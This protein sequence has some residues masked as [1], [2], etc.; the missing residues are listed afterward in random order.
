MYRTD[1][2]YIKH[3][4]KGKVNWHP[5]S[6]ETLLKASVL[7]RP[8]MVHIG[9]IAD[10][11]LRKEAYMLFEN[12][13][14]TEILNSK[15]I[16]IALDTED[17]PEAYL[18]GMD[19][20]LINEQ[21]ISDYINIFFLPG[22]KPI[23]SFSSMNAE[24]FLFVANNVSTTFET[25]RQK[26]E[27]A[28]HYL[29]QQLESS[30]IVT[31]KRKPSKISSKLLHAYI[32]SWATRFLDKANKFRRTP[33]AISPKNLLFILEYAHKYRVKEYLHYIEETLMHLYHSPMFDPIE[34]GVFS[35][36][37]DYCF[38]SPSYHKSIVQNSNAAILFSTA[39][40]Y[41][42]NNTFKEAAE[43]IAH[44]MESSMHHNGTGYITFITLRNTPKESK[45]YKYS[46]QELENALPESSRKVAKALGMDP[47]EDKKLFQRI[48]NT[49]A[50]W[51][52]TTEELQKLKQIRK[53]RQNEVIYDRRAI[54]GYN[55]HTATAFCTMAKN[56][57]KE[58]KKGYTRLSGEIIENILKHKKKE[59]PNLYKY[60]SSSKLEYSVSDLY[61]YAQFLNCL[62]HHYNLT[63]EEKYRTL[64]YEYAGYIMEN[65]YDNN[66]GMFCKTGKNNSGTTF[67]RAP[68]MDYNTVSSNAVMAENLLMLHKTT[69]DDTTYI[70]TFEQQLYN[71]EHQLV[72]S[73]PFMTGWGIQM[74]KYLSFGNRISPEKE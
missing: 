3:L 15:F 57:P 24:D 62:L 2:P 70:K 49:K 68:V 18:A 29:G 16:S 51:D 52:I 39:Y 45:Y 63:K 20:L 33:Y 71:I 9:N 10:A 19:L 44:F 53:T 13:E 58:E 59:G 46:M 65:H 6:T 25:D 27:L 42:K 50:Y 1:S 67:K 36:A 54:T 22:L 21:R 38:A 55:C 47:D 56:S 12:G 73:G 28:G 11:Q 7:D 61:D 74:L 48:S 37:D 31:E 34:G 60:I 43:R 30:G 8:I 35:Q 40:K 26:L 72:G 41:L 69:K 17:L 23:T 5:F 32:K 64:C 14:V 66:T 4:L